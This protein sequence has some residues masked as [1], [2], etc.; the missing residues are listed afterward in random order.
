MRSWVWGGCLAAVTAGGVVFVYSG[1]G[2][3]TT[4][5]G[6]CVPVA[7]VEPAPADPA[8]VGVT[9]VVDVHKELAPREPKKLPFVSFD[10]PPLAKRPAARAEPPAVIPAAF[11]DRPQLLNPTWTYHRV[12]HGVEVHMPSLTAMPAVTWTT[13]RVEIAPTPRAVGPAPIPL[14]S[15]NDP[16]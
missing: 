6:R 4:H 12:R 13:T 7:A 3:E 16:F 15:P 11:D 1:T 10:E 9:E 8:P 5:C 14:A 2:G